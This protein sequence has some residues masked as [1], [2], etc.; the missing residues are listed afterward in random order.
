M[1]VIHIQMPPL[2]EMREDIPSLANYYLTNYCRQMKKEPMNLAPQATS[3]CMDYSWP[4][5]VR[6]LENEMKRLV[7]SVGGN[8]V[9]QEDLSEAIRRSGAQATTS[10][11]AS[12]Y[13]KD[14]VSELKRRMIQDALQQSRQNQLHAAKALGLS[15]HGLIKKMKLY[16][17]RVRDS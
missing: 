4:G 1:K 11:S 3:A 14:I 8:T 13:L 17:I 12:R 6:E 16:N 7:L 2:R 15:R 9:V 5:N 10:A